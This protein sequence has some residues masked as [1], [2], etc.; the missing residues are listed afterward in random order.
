MAPTLFH[1]IN[2]EQDHKNIL[3][4]LHIIHRTVNNR[5]YRY[6][7]S[8]TDTILLEQWYVLRYFDK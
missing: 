3:H 8:Q 7:A 5:Q 6:K 1:N 2:R 4:I